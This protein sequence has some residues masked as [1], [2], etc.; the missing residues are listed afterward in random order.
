MSDLAVGC[1]PAF[2]KLCAHAL[3][4]LAQAGNSIDL[5]CRAQFL[6]GLPTRRVPMWKC[7][8]LP[9]HYIRD[10]TTAACKSLPSFD[11]DQ[12]L[13]HPAPVHISKHDG[14]PH[15]FQREAERL[16]SSSDI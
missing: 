2:G 3:E 6:P 9:T 5:P 12:S 7:S 14:D 4:V 10:V 1:S 13:H 15:S 11:S 16:S 8:A